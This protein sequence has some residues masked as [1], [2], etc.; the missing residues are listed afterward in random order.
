MSDDS[1]KQETLKCDFRCLGFCGQCKM[2]VFDAVDVNMEVQIWPTILYIL[3][4]L[5]VS[6]D[7]KNVKK[8]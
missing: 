4:N 8:I 1:L 3:F 5:K 2:L 6:K 7:F